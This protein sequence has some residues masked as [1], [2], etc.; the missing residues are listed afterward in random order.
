MLC[1]CVCLPV[2]LGRAAAGPRG[3]PVAGA[4]GWQLCTRT[5]SSHVPPTHLPACPLQELERLFPGEVAADGSKAKIR[6]YKVVKT[7]LSV[8]KTIPDCEPCRPTQ[9]TPVRACVCVCPLL[10]G[11]VPS[12]RVL[13]LL[14]RLCVAA[15]ACCCPCLPRSTAP[16][17]ETCLPSCLPAGLLTPCLPLPPFPLQVRN[18]YLAGDYTKQ[19]YLA[20]MEGATFSGKLC[21]KAI[22]G[23]RGKARLG[24]EGARAMRLEGG[25]GQGKG[26]RQGAGTVTLIDTGPDSRHCILLVCYSYTPTPSSCLRFSACRGL[27]HFQRA[28]QPARQGARHGISTTRAC[29]HAPRS[30]APPVSA[31][32]YEASH[33]PCSSPCCCFSRIVGTDST[34]LDFA[35]KQYNPPL[36]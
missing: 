5:Y 6:K 4:A 26:A 34:H 16:P 35:Q 29:M 13:L 31:R 7:P 36:S 9:R 21:A 2:L 14:R 32:P 22:A 12:L 10:H 30:A 11:P 33:T 3:Q 19:R 18:F 25:Q 15:P 23:A 27:E 8:Y 20:S 1:V 28:A 24:R 17:S